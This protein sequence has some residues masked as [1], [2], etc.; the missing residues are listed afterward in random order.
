MQANF[1]GVIL[2]DFDPVLYKWDHLSLTIY[3]VLF[4]AGF[5]ISRY[6]VQYM[7]LREGCW[8]IEADML[9]VYMIVG[10]AIGARL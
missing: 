9:L 5:A 7:F 6:V 1:I 4:A 10:T 3:G 2:I 8:R